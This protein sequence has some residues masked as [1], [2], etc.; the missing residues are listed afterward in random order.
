MKSKLIIILAAFI[1][2]VTVILLFY[3]HSTNEKEVVNRYRA[4]QLVASRQLAREIESYLHDRSRGVEVL[5]TFSILQH[6]NMSEIAATIKEYFEYLK[7]DH[8]KAISVYDEKGTIIYSTTKESIGQ[9]YAE[10]DFFHWAVKKENK[11]KQFI[12]SLIQKTDNQTA[13]L[14]YFRFLIAAPIY[15]EVKN[16]RDQKPTLKFVGIVTSTIDLEEVVSAFLPLVSAYNANE[17]AYIL[18]KSGTVILQSEH[19]GMVLHNIFR[20]DKSCN[21]C[22]VSFDHVKTI[23]SRS[24]GT[25]EYAFKEKQKELASFSSM[26]FN[27]ISW[28]IVICIPYE[29]VSGF[30]NRNLYMTFILIGVITLTLIGGSS[31]IYRSNR[32]KI[33]AEEEAK[34]WMEKRELEDKI[35]ESEEH[36]RTVVDISADAIIIHCEGKIVFVNQAAVKLVG[37]SSAGDL[38]GKPAIEFVHPDERESIGKRILE[39]LKSGKSSQWLEERFIRMD[40]STIYVETV[41]TPTTYN[42]KPSVQVIIHDITEKMQARESLKASEE[43]YRRLVENLGKEYFFYRHDRDGV[44]TYVSNSMTDMLGYSKQEFL[45]HHTEHH[46]GNPINKEAVKHTEL[47]IQ[48]EQQAPYEVEIYHKDK[49]II[50]LEVTEVPLRDNNGEVNAIEGIAKNIT[51]RKRAEDELQKSEKKYRDLVENALVG[52]YRTN[53]KGEILFVNDAMVKMLEYNSREEFLQ[54]SA[55]SRYK[56]PDNR[57]HLIETLRKEGSVNNFEID[58][59]TKNGNAKTVLL[60]ATLD[61]DVLSGMVRDITQRKR[62]EEEL[63]RR[64]QELSVLHTIDRAINQTLDLDQILNVA[65]D[66]TMEIL[67]ADAGGIY[68]LQEDGK[69]MLLAAHRGASDEFV[70]NVETIQFGE[71]ISGQAAVERKPVIMDIAKYPS[72]PLT[73]FLVKQGIQSLVSIPLLAKEDV[74][75]AINIISYRPN[76]FSQDKIETLQSIG[77]QIGVAIQNAELFEAERR[78]AKQLQAINRISQNIAVFMDVEKLFSRVVKLIHETFGYSYVTLVVV[79][80]KAN[81]IIYKAAAGYNIAEL[82][83]SNEK[84]GGE[85]IIQWVALSGNPLLTNDV[86]KESRFLYCD[87]LKYSRSELTLPIMLRNKVVAVLDIQ[88]DKLNAFNPDDFTTIETVVRDIS[89]ALE[90]AQ[91]YEELKISH[92]TYLGIINSLTEAI[93]IQDENGVFLEV[94]KAAEK[95]YGHPKE[96]FIG[97]T[98]GLI[99]APG[100]N[101]IPM[102]AEAVKK[103]FNGEPQSFEFWGLRK[104]GTIFPKSVNL[105]SG[106]YFGKKVVIATA[107]D[108]TERKRTEEEIKK[109]NHIYIVLSNI[110]QAIVRI[111]EREQLFIETCRIAVDD[112]KFRMAWLG[113]VNSQTQKVEAVASAGLI[114]DYLDKIDIDLSSEKRSKGPTGRT[115]QSGTHFI[116]NDIENDD[117]MIPWKEDAKRLS[118]RSSASFPLKVFGKTNGCFNLYSSEVGFFDEGEIKLLDELATDIS[119]ALEF[120]E[121]EAQR[122]QAEQEIISQKNRFAQLFEN[123][124]IAIVLLDD[125]DKIIHINESFSGLFGYFLEEVKGESLNDLIVPTELKEEAE[126]YSDQTREG[127][128]INKE[129][130]RK[131]KDGT[132]VYVQIVGVPVTAND[133][134]VGIYGMYVD[135]TQRKDAEEKMKSAKELAEQS[136]KMK[137]EFLAQMSHEIRTPINII[138]SNVNF[139]SEE[140][141]DKIDPADKD[142]FESID[143]A[144]RRIIR[145]VDL[146][147]NMSELQTGI[148]KPSLSKVDIE[149]QVLKKLYNEFQQTAKQKGIDFIY[150]CEVNESEII[151]DEYC[152]TQIFVNLVDNAIKYTKKGKVEILLTKN[153]DGNIVVEVKDTGIGISKDFFPHLFE[154]FV[155]ED[156]G[157][158]RSY[159]G[160]GLGLALVK[161]Y[162]DINNAV[163][164]VESEK[165]VGSTFRVIFK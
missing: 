77:I 1:F 96:Y 63:H 129:S 112:G 43:K 111:H 131:K 66:K 64:N 104:N 42:S 60:S 65:V 20:Q 85:G 144:S 95:F 132:L 119:F 159:E 120:I 44:F 39:I 134:T 37:A 12:S 25:V 152:V 4:E 72:S 148:Y 70:K 107:R 19:R 94:N 31:L 78:K 154:P 130:Y 82:K 33:R 108:I 151:S 22:H 147:L 143:L 68:L 121:R 29:E 87:V 133:K 114:N 61:G 21:K 36:Y 73:T 136:D 46:T 69:T 125:Q 128:Q 57:K 45:I 71:G 10:C 163:I 7:K 58:I 150:K 113:M 81:E 89:V 149:S 8:V 91:L 141:G 86:S 145:T 138:T 51:K 106:E 158:S 124:P 15:Q 18:D 101:D 27:N 11:G 165:N 102:I 54:S 6:L 79:D 97:K 3:L 23:I 35:R 38:I 105:T 103:A 110:N 2:T 56:N 142:C 55:L 135:L 98:P 160:N 28:K 90:N 146:I 88:S 127:N 34:Q 74:L 75:G 17:H 52:V 14:P 126:S 100:K 137:T 59:L 24:E 115:I 32:L 48:G 164:E 16:T 47:S 153:K 84:L 76:A 49:S 40:G 109:L 118:F 50:W 123:S 41:G 26:E 161:R 116:V 5:S 157:Y 139:I 156:Q 62:A 117:T 67:D 122:K 162:C 93:Y 30:I 83:K 140:L 155:Q 9:N 92:A 99:S 53:L 80:E 13:P